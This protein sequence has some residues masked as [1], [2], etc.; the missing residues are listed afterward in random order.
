MRN[1][2]EGSSYVLMEKVSQNMG[3]GSC[4]NRERTGYLP[5]Y[6]WR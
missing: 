3:G 4:S 2:L 5:K 1:N 6:A